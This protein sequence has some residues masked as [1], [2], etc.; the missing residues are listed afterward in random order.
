M[1]D[2]EQYM[3][4][5]Y[6]NLLLPENGSFLFEARS[7]KRV[8]NTFAKRIDSCQTAQSAQADMGR[9]FSLSLVFLQCQR[10]VPHHD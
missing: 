5:L 4:L 1:T 10:I 6:Y 7:V 3:M 2:L 8:L 9:N